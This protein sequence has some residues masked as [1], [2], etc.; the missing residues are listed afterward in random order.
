MRSRRGHILLACLIVALVAPLL[1]GIFSQGARRV[2]SDLVADGLLTEVSR[3]DISGPESRVALREGALGWIFEQDGRYFPARDARV[4]LLID[5]VRNAAIERLVTA[6]ESLWDRFGVGADATIMSFTSTSA[7]F[8]MT[9]G[10]GPDGDATFVRRDGEPEVYEIDAAIRFF[11]EQ[12]PTFWLMLRIL[13]RDVRPGEVIRVRFTATGALREAGASGVFELVRGG[14][15]DHSDGWSVKHGGVAE[16]STTLSRLDGLELASQVVD[17]VGASFWLGE[18][19]ELEAAGRIGV[20]LSD[21]RT[22]SLEI[23]GVGPFVVDPSGSGL[24]GDP[25]GGLRYVVDTA[26]LV[27]LTNAAE[28]R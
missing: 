6:E 17:M 13:P 22:F 26:R 9:V 11:A 7:R 21:G 28:S 20:D 5:A 3:V 16:A 23:R 19:N 15:V 2:E 27:R 12:S 1:F 18:W 14:G 10:S 8:E 24:P 4:Q 25:Y